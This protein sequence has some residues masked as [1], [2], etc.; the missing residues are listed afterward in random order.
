MPADT[1]AEGL[2]EIGELADSWAGESAEVRKLAVAEAAVAALAERDEPAVVVE[3]EPA[4]E[5]GVVVE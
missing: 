2:V 5:D 3:A 4:A 1:Q